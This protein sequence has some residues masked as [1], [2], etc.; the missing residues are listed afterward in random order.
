MNGV[1][2]L[3]CD[4]ALWPSR[5]PMYEIGH[6]LLRSLLSIESA[7]V[8]PI[9]QY[10]F[11][12]NNPCLLVDANGEFIPLLIVALI[13]TTGWA[14]A[15]ENAEQASDPRWQDPPP[16]AKVAQAILLARLLTP[17]KNP[18]RPSKAPTA[19]EPPKPPEPFKP[20]VE[21]CFLVREL[22]M[23]LPG[24]PSNTGNPICDQYWDTF[25]EVVECLYRCPTMGMVTK[26]RPGGSTCLDVI[27]QPV[28]KMK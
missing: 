19:P 10:N 14:I 13:A 7:G 5:D 21:A 28:F 18:L 27:L 22:R 11:V 25:S 9:N 8:T 23:K 26:T 17:W 15:P 2:A 4:I 16:E 6:K 3:H 12:F 20:Q 24:P 1:Q